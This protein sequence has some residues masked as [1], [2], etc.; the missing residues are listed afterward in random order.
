MPYAD[1]S[2]RARQLGLDLERIAGLLADGEY[3]ANFN[4]VAE[5]GTKL[6]GDEWG[7]G[8]TWRAEVDV[9]APSGLGFGTIS[10]EGDTKPEAVEALYR[11][12]EARIA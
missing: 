5:R 12:L 3:I 7:L 10:A 6:R 8:E 4:V 1:P 2:T 9:G 11:M